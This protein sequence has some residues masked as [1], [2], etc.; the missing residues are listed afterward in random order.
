MASVDDTKTRLLQAAGKVFAAKGFEAATVREIC[1]LASVGNIAAVNYYFRDKETLYREAVRHAYSCRLSSLPR[2][3]WPPDMAPA[4]K[5]RRFLQGI[6]AALL[7]GPDEQWQRE[8]MMRELAHPSE[9]CLEFVRHLVRPAFELLLSILDEIVLP[10]T[11]PV[12][13]H[14]LALSIVGQCVYHKLARPI[15]GMLVG[16]EEFRTYDAGRLADHIA[17]FSLT[18]LGLEPVA[19]GIRH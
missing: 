2:P 17:S 12:K 14:L 13:R 6:L 11:P 10:E 5:L 3:D 19:L 9:G 4:D 15:V 8:L 1:R 7:E 18:A 16:E